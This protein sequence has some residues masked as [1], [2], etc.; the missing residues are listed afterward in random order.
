M[1]EISHECQF[2]QIPPWA[3]DKGSDVSEDADSLLRTPQVNFAIKNLKSG[4]LRCTQFF[5]LIPFSAAPKRE[6]VIL[7]SN[8]FNVIELIEGGVVNEGFLIAS[9]CVF[10]NICDKIRFITTTVINHILHNSGFTL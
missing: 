9:R 5:T 6:R 2:I 8:L 4:L 3:F 10:I 1:S 7:V